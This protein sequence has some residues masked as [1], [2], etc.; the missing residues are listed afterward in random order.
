MEVSGQLH[1]SVALPSG[2]EPL[3]LIEKGAGWGPGP[4]WMRWRRKSPAYAGNR[5]LVIQPVA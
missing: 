2:K 4:V 5:T 3:I 1:A